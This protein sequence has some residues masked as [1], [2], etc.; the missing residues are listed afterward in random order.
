MN[1]LSRLSNG[2]PFQC[3]QE[4]FG[5]PGLACGII[6]AA[7]GNR[8]LDLRVAHLQIVLQF[9]GRHDADNRNPVLLQDEV[10]VAVVRPPGN[11]AQIDPRLG[12]GKPID[13]KSL[14]NID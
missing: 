3:S 9:I 10:F 11:L 14:M 6:L 13:R 7:H 4:L 5:G 8:G 2:A 12:D 1:T